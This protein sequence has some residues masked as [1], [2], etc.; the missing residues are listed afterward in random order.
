MSK[1]CKQHWESWEHA[2]GDRAELPDGLRKHISDCPSCAAQFGRLERVTSALA[3]LPKLSAPSDLEG[4]VAASFGAGVRQDRVVR[5][6]ESLAPAPAPSVLGAML[7][8][9][10]MSSSTEGAPEELRA[11]VDEELEVPGAGRARSWMGHLPRAAAPEELHLRVD[12]EL[13]LLHGPRLHPRTPLRKLHPRKVLAGVA[14]A[15]LMLLLGRT[16]IQDSE[17]TTDRP[18]SGTDLASREPLSF[19]L[20]RVESANS[21]SPLARGLFRGVQGMTIQTLERAE[22]DGS[23]SERAR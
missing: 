6:L 18:D 17:P 22:P 7:E 21:L 13:R 16:W 3:S 5:E 1:H 15:A 19:Q 12:R 14:A 8:S 2:S 23:A 11:R 10:Q 4:R 9:M 20:V